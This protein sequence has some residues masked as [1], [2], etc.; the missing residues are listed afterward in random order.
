MI[1]DYY[2]KGSLQLPVIDN[3]ETPGLNTDG[4]A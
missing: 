3:N 1:N 4:I 2:S